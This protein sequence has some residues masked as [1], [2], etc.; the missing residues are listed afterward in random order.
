M[1]VFK[2]VFIDKEKEPV[3]SQGNKI[4]SKNGKYIIENEGNIVFSHSKY[5]IS[6]ISPINNKL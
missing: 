5:E 2:V 1:K 6:C 4:Y 3:F